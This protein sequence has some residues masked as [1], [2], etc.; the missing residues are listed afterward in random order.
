MSSV[1]RLSV[2]GAI[3]CLGCVV[4]QAAAQI[5][6]IRMVD[7]TEEAGIDWVHTNGVTPEK[8]LIETMG[9]GGAVLDYDRDG[10][11]DIF[12][13]DSG[14]HAN[15]PDCA[16][17]G[18]RLYR[19]AS[20]GRFEDVTSAAG[21][22]A[23]GYGMGVAV[24][25][26][27]NDGFPDIYITRYGP[28]VLYL[29]NGDGTF[30]DITDKSGTGD[31]DWSVSAAFFD[32]NRDGLPDLFVGDYLTWDY[33]LKKLC[34][35]DRPGRRSYCHPNQFALIGSRLY[36]NEG[37]GVFTDV[38]ESSGIGAAKGKALGVVAFD[39]DS[40]GWPDLHVANDTE[41]NFLFHNQGDG[42]FEE[43]ALLAELAYGISGKPESGM[44][45]DAADFD[46]DGLSDLTVTNFHNEVNSLLHN[47]GDL[48]FIDVTLRAGLGSVALDFSGFG[49]RFVDYDN[50]GDLD[51]FVVNGH[52]IDN[53]HLFEE[54]VEYAERPF[55]FRNTGGR[56][57]EIGASLGEVFETPYVGR[58]LVTGD[59]DND[60]DVDF[61]LVNNGQRPVLL[62]NDGG[63][64]R[65]WIG[66]ELAGSDSGRDA[67]GAR[68][69]VRT[70]DNWQMRE[71][72]GGASYAAAHDLRL[73]FG[74]GAGETAEE[75]EIRWPSGVVTRLEGLA[76]RQYHRVE[77]PPARENDS[78]VPDS[79]QI[80]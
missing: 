39:V 23:Q 28:N 50:D 37:E 62:R 17:T 16:A 11:L 20:A 22:L 67:F 14:C 60:G 31:P 32:Y 61:L 58:A 36:R 79:G 41:P 34:G 4:G 19:Q 1:S 76:A 27:N 35:E 12:L 40:D 2:L 9:G 3:A 38:S 29:N 30:R 42:T 24:G 51:V 74:L 18:S 47:N 75:V 48:T 55:F 10:W 26:I 54:G 72:V 13:V 56:F 70:G 66:F 21:L 46:G 77:E 5:P 33:E 68:V 53:I 63:N 45:T 15:S 64:A 8:Y 69:R 65:S 73:L 57:E 71:I 78:E 7:V 43:I 49:T 59:Y 52:V 25:D 80:D 6:A 44:G